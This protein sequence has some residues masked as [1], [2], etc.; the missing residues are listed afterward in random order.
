MATQARLTD[1]VIRPDLLLQELLAAATGAGA[2]VNFCGLVRPEDHEGRKIEAL[3]LDHHPRLT[4]RSLETIA[5][6][7]AERF[8]LSTCLV[9][10][11]FGRIEPGATVVF[12]GAAALHRRAA[13]MGADYL[14]DRLKSEAMFWKKE[15]GAAGGQWIEPTNEDRADLL[16]WGN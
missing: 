5:Q 1:D 16:R 12:V 10:H 9:V 7:G 2:I 15:E 13:F 14:M 11:R 8:G 3:R 6:D 4:L